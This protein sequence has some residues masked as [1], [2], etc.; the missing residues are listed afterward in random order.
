MR[1]GR[2]SGKPWFLMLGT[3][4]FLISP[5]L[6]PLMRNGQATVDRYDTDA[7]QEKRNSGAFAIILGDFRTSLGDLIFIKTERYL[8]SGIAY[9]PHIDAAEMAKSGEIHQTSSEGKQD[10]GETKKPAHPDENRTGTASAA[11][12]G[13]H[14][15][16]VPTII[17]SANSDFRGFIGN[18][19]REVKPWQ[20]PSIPHQHTGG[21]QLLPWYR[22]ATLSDPRNVRNYMIGAWW[23]KTI[24][25]DQE[26]NEALKFLNEGI[27]N[28]PEAY[29]L[30]LMRGYVEMQ[31]ENRAVALQD[32][33]KSAEL[34]KKHRPAGGELTK[35][36]DI[37]DEEQGQ[38]AISM[39]AGIIRD[40]DGSQAGGKYLD[41]FKAMY[42]SPS[43]LDRIRYSMKV[44]DDEA[45]SKSASEHKTTATLNGKSDGKTSGAVAHR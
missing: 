9:M 1:P 8:D 34:V 6:M 18:L 14:E 31:M 30:Y 16:N 26:T 20:D 45:T 7:A 2:N 27:V 13:D 4:L 10:K 22:L 42:P 37:N 24:H 12:G 15:E 41:Q 35:E 11:A 39:A 29:Q 44:L 38:A 19:E 36:W 43:F 25:T 32:F 3:G 33:E 21:T 28:N 17:K 23:L 40:K 5:A